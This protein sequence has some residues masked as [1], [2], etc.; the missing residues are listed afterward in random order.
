MT[1]V[2]FLVKEQNVSHDVLPNTSLN[3]ADWLFMHKIW[4]GRRAHLVKYEN[5]NNSA[6]D[7]MS[8]ASFC[9]S[10]AEYLTNP[11]NILYHVKNR[12]LP[13]ASYE[14]CTACLHGLGVSGII[15]HKVHLF[16]INVKH[17]YACIVSAFCFYEPRLKTQ[18]SSYKS[19]YRYNNK[20]INEYRLFKLFITFY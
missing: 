13:R 5:I 15:L 12:F 3:A 7:G 9:Q 20:T 11:N 6:L 1:K 8:L 19:T 4:P 14:S 16:F 2:K 10:R 17:F 18:F